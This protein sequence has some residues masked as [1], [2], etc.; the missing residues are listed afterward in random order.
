MTWG[1]RLKDGTP[2]TVIHNFVTQ[3][4]EGEDGVKVMVAVCGAE[5]AP[6]DF[7]PQENYTPKSRDGVCRRC[8]DHWL[9]NAPPTGQDQGG[10][11][12]G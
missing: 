6:Y 11:H 5:V 4:R 8:F 10:Q 9:Y 2:A 3:R 12:D 1:V 7:A